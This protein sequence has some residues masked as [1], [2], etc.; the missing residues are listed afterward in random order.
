VVGIGVNV[1][2]RADVPADLASP[3]TALS[4]VAGLVVP[5]DRLAAA[6]L[7]RLEPLVSDLRAGGFPSDSWRARQ[8][9]NGALVRIERPDGSAETVRAI[10]VDAESGALVIDSLSGEW[11]RRS[12]TVG[13]IRHVRMA[14]TA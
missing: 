4:W 8:L 13:E 10:D 6:F 1:A 3:M 2:W 9:T 5:V 7:E 12:V 14:G 11:P